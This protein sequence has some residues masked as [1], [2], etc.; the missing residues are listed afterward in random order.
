MRSIKRGLGRRDCTLITSKYEIP[1]LAKILVFSFSQFNTFSKIME[2]ITTGFA[3][4]NSFC[5]LYF[6]STIMDPWPRLR[7]SLP[8]NFTFL[9]LG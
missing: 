6:V 2:V 3:S 9:Q 1:L 7:Q 4:F 5:C 8:R